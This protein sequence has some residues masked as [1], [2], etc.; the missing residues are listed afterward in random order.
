MFEELPGITYKT[1]NNNVI[2][3]VD[4]SRSMYQ[5]PLYKDES[6]FSNIESYVNFIKGCERKVR[7]NDRY[8]KY[9][10]YLKNV[11]GLNHCQVLPDIEPESSKKR[12]KWNVPNILSP[13][14][15]AF[16]VKYL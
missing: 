1:T 16:L 7:E 12:F 3:I 9:I 14:T 11:V 4:S 13:L 6:F 8:R 10:Y 15:V 2:P 5:I